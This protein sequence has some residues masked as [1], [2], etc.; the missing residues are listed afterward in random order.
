MGIKTF[1]KKVRATVRMEGNIRDRYQAHGVEALEHYRDHGDSSY[2]VF[3][4]NEVGLNSPYRPLLIKWC[5]KH[6]HLTTVDHPDN[7]TPAGDNSISFVT[8]KDF[9]P[10]STNVEAAADDHFWEVAG[11]PGKTELDEMA[12]IQGVLKRIKANRESGKLV[13]TNR[14]PDAMLALIERAIDRKADAA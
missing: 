8:A 3:L 5:K 4:C 14:A 13:I 9:K 7:D 10:S 6:G 12:V 1:A 11:K 2:L